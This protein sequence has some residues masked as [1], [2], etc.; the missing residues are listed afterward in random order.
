MSRN[1]TARGTTGNM[2]Y[3]NY[4]WNQKWWDE[5]SC[6]LSGHR[7]A[8]YKTL[9]NLMSPDK[10]GY[11]SYAELL[12][13]LTK[14]F[15]P[16]PSEIVEQLKFHSHRQEAWRV[17]SDFH[18]WIAF[19]S[20]KDEWLAALCKSSCTRRVKPPL[21]A[22]AKTVPTCYHCGTKGHTVF[23]WCIANNMVCHHCDGWGQMQWA[24]SKHQA[25]QPR[26]SWEIHEEC[27]NSAN[28]ISCS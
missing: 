2:Q 12:E 19:L 11:K 21:L 18:C 3:M 25:I 4:E 27:V 16:A 6:L 20:K 22:A 14:H 17:C 23:R 9:C 8:M 13:A 5:A 24:K 26:T 28:A 1:L 7:L 10:P 15:K